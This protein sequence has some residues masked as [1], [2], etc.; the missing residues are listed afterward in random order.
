MNDL[1]LALAQSTFRVGDLMGNARRM[2]RLAEQ[3]RDRGA[4]IIVFP[5][6]ALTGYPPE[7]LLLRPNLQSRVQQAMQLIRAVQGIVMIVGYP[8]ADH[9][10]RFNSAAVIYNGQQRGFY[11]KQCLPNYGVFDEQRYFQAGRNHV[12]FDFQGRKIGLLICEDLWQKAPIQQ[13]AEQGAELVLAINA[14]PFEIGKHQQRRTLLQKRAK[15]HQLPIAYVNVVGGQDDLVFD[16]GSLAV[17]ADGQIAVDA[18]RFSEQLTFVKLGAD[19]RFEAQPIAEELSPQ[20]ETYQALVCAVRDYVNHSGFS[21]VVLGLSG[22]IDSALT[23]AIAVDALGPE[24]VNAVM[25]PYQYTAAISVEDAEAQARRLGVSFNVSEIHGIVHSFQ[26][27]LAPYFGNRPVDATEENIQAR[28]RG[29][30]LMA[31]SNKFGLLVLTTG[32]KS[33]VAVGYCTLYG[34][35]AGGFDVLKDVYKT[36]VF[37]LARYRNSLEPQPVIPERVITRPPSAE[38]RPDQKDQDSLPPYEVAR[39]HFVWLISKKTSAWT[40]SSP[41]ALRPKW[42]TRCLALSIATSTNA[43]KRRLARASVAVPLVVNA[44]I[45][46]SIAGRSTNEPHCAAHQCPCSCTAATRCASGTYLSTTHLP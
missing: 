13:L 4:Q 16:G 17:N 8:H 28:A 43:V 18:P 30:L 32:N 23:L 36:Q 14:S 10:R 15:T 20:A 7:D 22:G 42:C 21:G 38:L 45:L 11:H 1:T 35:M 5:E 39:C 25:M 37:E 29:T 34:D 31:L 41:K 46:W 2:V 33:E 3:A 6:L 44:V 24:R 12:M 26:Q 19:N 40:C 27:T 9:Q